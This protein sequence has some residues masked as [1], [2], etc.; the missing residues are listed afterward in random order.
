MKNK[1]T[2]ALLAAL[3]TTTVLLSGCSTQV[4]P[5]VVGLYYM[6]GSSDGYAFGHCMKSGAAEDYEWDNEVIFL[7]ASLRTWIIAPEGGDTTTPIVVSAKPEEGQP[8]GVAV[9][10]WSQTT[11]M[12][13]T[14]CDGEKGGPLKDFWEKIG[15]RYGANTEEGWKKMMAATII[16]ALQKS[17]NDNIRNFNAD[18]LNANKD[19]VLTKVQEAVGA[20]FGVELKKLTGGDF[21]CGPAFVPGGACPAVSIVITDV[22][23]ADA[24]L[25]AARN[26][27]QKA[28]ELAAAKLAEAQGAV[29][30]AAEMDKL[31]QNKAWVALKIAEMQ[32]EEARVCAASPKCIMVRGD[33]AKVNLTQ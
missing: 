33:G 1:R 31:Y 32:L 7:P 30:A 4:A 8:S 14:T 2:L 29:R 16:P 3:T 23:L 26:E 19:G 12:L 27:K 13:N 9:K 18:D 22:E 6:K 28:V 17:I 15:K 11:F 21:F 24:S 20:Q 10:V 5:D 25:Q